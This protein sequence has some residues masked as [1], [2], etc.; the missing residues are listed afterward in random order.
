M[1][2]NLQIRFYTKDHS[3]LCFKHAVQSAIEG[4]DVKTEVDEF[5][6]EFFACDLCNNELPSIE[7]LSIVEPEVIAE[8]GQEIPEMKKFLIKYRTAFGIW[9]EVPMVAQS[10][11]RARNRFKFFYPHCTLKS[12]KEE[13]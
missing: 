11:G 13:D 12:I 9:K 10:E 2:L 4:Q 3:W 1:N 8:V 5:R 7:E 6:T